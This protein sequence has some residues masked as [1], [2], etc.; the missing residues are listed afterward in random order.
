MHL[1]QVSLPFWCSRGV[2]KMIL[3]WNFGW[4][5]QFPSSQIQGFLGFFW[6]QMFFSILFPHSFTI[7]SQIPAAKKWWFQISN[8]HACANFLKH[9][10]LQY[11]LQEFFTRVWDWL[12]LVM[13]HPF[14]HQMGVE[15]KIG[16]FYHPKWMVKIL[17]N[18]IK[19]DDL[20]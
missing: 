1:Y 2:V 9:F 12:I 3:F 13:F 20:G 14:Y 18:P 17:K 15:P 19:M 11:K 8:L 5:V 6:T 10:S 4:R 7:I 16:F